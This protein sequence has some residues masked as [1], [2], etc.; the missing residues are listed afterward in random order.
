MFKLHPKQFYPASVLSAM[1]TIAAKREL[2]FEQVLTEGMHDL[3]A[4]TSMNYSEDFLYSGVSYSTREIIIE[5]RTIKES[6]AKN[7]K[8]IDYLL[9]QKK[10]VD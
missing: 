4:L 8:Y 10:N 2:S 1:D 6:R 9:F 3:L 5:E 7:Q